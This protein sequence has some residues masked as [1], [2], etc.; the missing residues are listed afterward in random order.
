[1]SPLD[2]VQVSSSIC[3]VRINARH[4]LLLRLAPIH[5]SGDGDG[6]DAGRG[7][8]SGSGGVGAAGNPHLSM[9]RLVGL[10]LQ[11]SIR[12]RQRASFSR[13]EHTFSNSWAQQKVLNHRRPTQHK[14]E[15]EAAGAGA[16]AVDVVAAGAAAAGEVAPPL[17]TVV[18]SLSHLLF[19][20]EVSRGLSELAT[21]RSSDRGHNAKK[22]A[23]WTVRWV[24]VRAGETSMALVLRR[25]EA[26]S[27]ASGAG[28]GT[29]AAKVVARGSNCISVIG[30]A[31]QGAAEG[32]ARVPCLTFPDF[33]SVGAACAA[34]ST[35]M[36]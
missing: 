36:E 21:E 14:G 5:G 25:T 27:T 35:L 6:D 31:V 1:M 18:A 13:I 19:Q 8:G 30:T 11:R 20:E 34:L 12:R 26:D 9:C 23:V 29:V 28:G 7:S 2:V 32:A 22:A 4:H 10:L 3:E 16:A 24:D 15:G 33:E 17:A